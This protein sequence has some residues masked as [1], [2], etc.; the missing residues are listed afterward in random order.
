MVTFVV[1]SLNTWM[2]VSRKA[3]LLFF[4]TSVVNLSRLCWL[5]RCIRN[6]STAAILILHM[7]SST[8][9][10]H[11]DGGSMKVASA[12]VSSL[13]I[14]NSAANPDDEAPWLSSQLEYIAFH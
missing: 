2:H 4:S 6:A 8:Y 5:F 1:L 3:I 14:N 7:V 9:L 11:S 12:L 13:T 10:F